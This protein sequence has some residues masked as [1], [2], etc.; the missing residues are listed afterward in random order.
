VSAKAS[1]PLR[2]CGLKPFAANHRENGTVGM[3]GLGSGFF[4]GFEATALTYFFSSKVSLF[5]ATKSAGDDYDPYEQNYQYSLLNPVTVKGIVTQVSPA[6]L[7]FKE[8]GLGQT[9]A[10]EVIT[11]QKYRNWFENAQRIVID[12]IDYQVYKFATGGRS[13]VQNRAGNMVRVF[14]TRKD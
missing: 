2:Q 11:E 8:I 5:F 1:M 3:V 12:D 9:G 10:V 4:S 6:S 14:L 13:Y 7:V